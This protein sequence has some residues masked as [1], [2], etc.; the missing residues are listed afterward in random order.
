MAK[1]VILAN[2]KASKTQLKNQTGDLLK[3]AYREP[4]IITDYGKD[5]HV[6]LHIDDYL[7]L[8]QNIEAMEAEK[9]RP[10]AVLP[11]PQQG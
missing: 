2:M 10:E 3:A 11:A 1:L 7:K 9:N 4:V 8:L 5:S 6:L